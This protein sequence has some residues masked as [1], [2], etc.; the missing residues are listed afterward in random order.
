MGLSN[1]NRKLNTVLNNI[2]WG[3]SLGLIF[4]AIFCAY[5][6]VLSI[7]RRSTRFD[8]YGTTLW[9]IMAVYL[10]GGVLGGTLLGVLRPFTKRRM[11][12]IFAG[13][14]V[15]IPLFTAIWATVAGPSAAWRSDA[16]EG[17]L[18]CSASLG[19][20]LGN[21]IWMRER[22]ASSFIDR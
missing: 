9:G 14:A 13:V 21:Y 1:G 8:A 10:T 16:L 15:L 20:F 18:F 4:T 12:A 17:I 11:G 7:A 22:D 5:V 3:L 19:A 2:R 6:C